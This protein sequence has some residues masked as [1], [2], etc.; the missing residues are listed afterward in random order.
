VE[1]LGNYI[2]AERL[3]QGR[4]TEIYLARREE[5]G[6]FSRQVAIKAMTGR[7][8]GSGD[9]MRAFLQETRVTGLLHHPNI[10]QAYDVDEQRGRYF[11]VLEYVPGWSVRAVMSTLALRRLWM[12]LD[13]AMTLV[14]CAADGLAHAHASGVVHRDVTPSN[15]MVGDEGYVKVI[16]FGGAVCDKLELARSQWGDVASRYSAPELVNDEPVDARADIYSLGALLYELTTGAQLFTGDD[17]VR[18]IAAGDVPSPSSLRRGYPAKLEALVVKALATKRDDRF[19]SATT[20][21]SA[22]ESLAVANRFPLSSLRLSS[23]LGTLYGG[24]A[25]KAPLTGVL[26]GSGKTRVRVVRQR[27]R[28]TARERMPTS[29][30]GTTGAG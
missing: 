9:S 2:V 5:A 25:D 8:A 24:V 13:V 30:S 27:H 1:R 26:R 22:L 28:S 15:L 18:R 20:L 19:R 3:A 23:F 14:A 29:D 10:I 12:P 4:T 7:L 16:D 6:G 11:M 21:Q 17:P